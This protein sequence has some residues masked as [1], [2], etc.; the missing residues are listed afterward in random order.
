[1]YVAE[2]CTKV[3]AYALCFMNARF[4]SDF[5]F[6]AWAMTAVEHNDPFHAMRGL[7]VDRL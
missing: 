4:P 5:H 2:S 1:M 6:H 3:Q 7:Y